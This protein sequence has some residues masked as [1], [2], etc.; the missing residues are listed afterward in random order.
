[1]NSFALTH[2]L[3]YIS[4]DTTSL[5]NSDAVPS[6]PGQ[7]D[8]SEL[9]VQELEQLGLSRVRLTEAGY[10]LAELP[11]TEGYENIPV[12]GLLA[13][14]DT[15]SSASGKDVKPQIVAYQGGVLPLG[16]SGAVLDPVQFP[17]LENMV[18]KTLVTTDGT[19][20]LGADNKAGIAAIMAAL[21]RIIRT[22][23]PHGKI[24]IAFTTDEEIGGGARYLDL[25]D[26]GADFAYTVDGGAPRL[27]GCQNFNSANAAVD[28]AG[29]PAHPGKAKG[30]MIN[31]LR[32]LM[33]FNGMLP[34]G[35]VPE[36]TEKMEGFFHLFE[37][38]GNAAQASGAYMIRDFETE[39]FEQRKQTMF[40]IADEI[41]R[42]YG[43]T[44]LTV[45]MKELGRNMDSE[46]RKEPYV[47]E[48][49][50]KAASA[51]GLNL[52]RYAIRGG[53][54]GSRLSHRGL[55]CP[56]LGTGG[57]NCHSVYEYLCVE[58][59]KLMVDMLAE[60]IRLTSTLPQK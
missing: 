9:L 3:K 40:R 4:I 51:V 1:M 52:T 57:Y 10:A 60:L 2:F 49:A 54:D 14:V 26:F 34:A 15:S 41:N 53:T 23:Q 5:E 36:Q 42:K 50:E 29:I 46:V 56:N 32:V 27:F 17:Q 59:L 38:S 19:T 47:L 35:E 43:R 45:T 55:P 44:V 31:A 39:S 33:E 11:A 48:L 28:A 20:L 25:K 8:L 22:G 58:E 16:N 12:M 21:E 13:H 37:M 7:V 6:T 30:V 24:C 18:G